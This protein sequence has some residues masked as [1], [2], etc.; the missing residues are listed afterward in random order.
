MD[1]SDLKSRL[2][3]LDR[4]I[5]QVEER[6]RLKGIFSADHQI[7]VSELHQRYRLLSKRLDKEVAEQEAQ[8]HHVSDLELSLRQWLDSLKIDMD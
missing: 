3:K 6:L 8:G 1:T 4:H 2:D 7:K 5:Q